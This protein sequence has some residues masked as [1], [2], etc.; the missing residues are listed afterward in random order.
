MKIACIIR[1]ALSHG[2]TAQI[3]RADTAAL[4]IEERINLVEK[5]RRV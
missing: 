2:E 4:S 5:L 1:R 3:A